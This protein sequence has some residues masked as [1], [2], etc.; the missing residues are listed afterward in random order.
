MKVG[1]VGA[2]GAGGYFAGRWWEAGI[3]VTLIA[4]GQHLE[5]TRRDG[6]RLVS[7]LGD[8]E[9]R[10]TVAA[11]PSALADAD[12]VLF[13]TKSWQLEEAVA[14][15]V[16]HLRT[17]VVVCG[18][19]NGLASIELLA[20]TVP[21]R[22]VLGA[23]CRIIS[24]IVEPGVILHIG[25]DPTI[26]I[27]EVAGQH[28]ERVTRLATLLDLGTRLSVLESLDIAADLWGKFL[29]AAPVS[30]IGAMTGM[31]IGAFRKD[32][33][34]R[35]LLEA[36]IDEV[37]SVGRARGID[38]GA[39]AVA[40]ALRFVDTLP[41]DGTSSMHRDFEAGRRTELDVLSGMVSAMGAELSIP[42]PTH[43]LITR[44]LLPRELAARGTTASA[45][46]NP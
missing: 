12:F 17:D 43:D 42:T 16:P 44:S 14:A 22:N 5:A 31:S 10:P 15:A 2:G 11:D 19:Q 24:R 28:S 32:P 21:Q 34:T 6:L 29:L 30:G 38:F 33:E 3:D 25:V 4:R 45:S 27:G 41:A 26:F 13:A 18:V 9:A 46:D 40:R 36:G 7:P 39:D 37:V 8:V 1:V 20:R 35:A 23:T